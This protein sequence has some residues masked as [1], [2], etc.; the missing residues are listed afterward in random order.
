MDESKTYG[1]V[2][3]NSDGHGF[4]RWHI[5]TVQIFSESEHGILPQPVLQV[6]ITQDVMIF[7]AAVKYCRIASKEHE[8]NFKI[9]TLQD[10]EKFSPP[11][12]LERWL[13][14]IRTK[15]NTV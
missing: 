5:D 10:W 4:R 9:L 3:T 7:E 6:F 15:R 12:F 2:V 11:T 13:K 14:R 8:L 1:F